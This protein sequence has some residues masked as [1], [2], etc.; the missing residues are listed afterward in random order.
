MAADALPA[1]ESDIDFLVALRH[2][3]E[4]IK[5]DAASDRFSREIERLIEM[6]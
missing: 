4:K 2:L 5:D 6:Y 3:V 1:D